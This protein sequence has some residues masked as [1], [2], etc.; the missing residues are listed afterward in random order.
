MHQPFEEWWKGQIVLLPLSVDPSV[1]VRIRDGVSNLRLSFSAVSD[2]C[3]SF[4]KEEGGGG[5]GVCGW[6]EASVSH[7]SSFLIF[8]F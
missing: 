2:L 4:Q 3:L 7:I 8:L 1:S 6:G 5:G